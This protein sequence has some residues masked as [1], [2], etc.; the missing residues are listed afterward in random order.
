MKKGIFQRTI[1]VL[2][3]VL[4]IA[5]LVAIGVY[6]GGW[7]LL[8][9]GFVQLVEAVKSNPVSAFGT[10]SGLIRMVVAVPVVLFVVIMLAGSGK[11]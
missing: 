5:V 6:V 10:A 8:V 3:N 7:L 1:A 9:G 11:N 2:I 4:I